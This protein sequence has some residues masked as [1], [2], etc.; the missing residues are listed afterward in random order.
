MAALNRT[1]GTKEGKNIGSEFIS[2]RSLS[3]RARYCLARFRKV[4]LFSTYSVKK[5][6]DIKANI[7][8]VVPRSFSL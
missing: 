5:T 3:N 7:K 2:R 6:M 4:S 8:S 1:E